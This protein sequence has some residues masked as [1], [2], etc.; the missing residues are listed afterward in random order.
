MKPWYYILLVIAVLGM[1]VGC[2]SSR[3]TGV[4]EQAPVRNRK[5]LTGVG[6]T[7]ITVE[8]FPRYSKSGESWD[9]YA[10]FKEKPDLYLTITW[11]DKELYGSETLD[12]VVWPGPFSFSRGLPA[13]IMPFDKPLLIE[14]H[15]EDGLSADDNM[16]YF[17]VVLKDYEKSRQVRLST[18]GGE[19]AIALTLEFTYD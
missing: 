2:R 1:S 14:L 16:G 13:D 18:P 7:A 8:T 9:A 3:Q 19:L 11:N 10:P 12:E 4:A 5:I 6:I 17:Q 15:D